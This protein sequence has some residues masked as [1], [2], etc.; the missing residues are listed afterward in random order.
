MRAAF[1]CAAALLVAGCG[2]R[3][4]GVPVGQAEAPGRIPSA[5]PL[6]PLDS[7]LAAADSLRADS[8]LVAAPDS[9]DAPLA[10]LD[11]AAA[12]A[13]FRS[14]A[15]A[16]RAGALARPDD[17]DALEAALEPPFRE[18]VLALTPRDFV[19]DGT[20]R[21]AT[22]RVGF[23]AAGRVVP[24]DEAVRDAAVTLAFD[25]VEGAYRLVALG[26]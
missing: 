3:A 4:P 19:R 12:W 20:R 9:L 11:F 22:V 16:G 13:E 18:R 25:V 17:R 6:V 24:E 21:T 1:V 5:S 23:D 2:Q 26:R 10:P 8:L 7:A 15:V 14:A